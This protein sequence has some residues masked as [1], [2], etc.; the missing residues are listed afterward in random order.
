VEAKR[1]GMIT[2]AAKLS[3]ECKGTPRPCQI[4][5]SPLIKLS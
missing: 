1:A 4:A 2:V 5:P 3:G